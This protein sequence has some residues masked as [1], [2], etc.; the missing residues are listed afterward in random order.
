[1]NTFFNVRM[2]GILPEIGFQTY[3]NSKN[4]ISYRKWCN[5]CIKVDLAARVFQYYWRNYKNKQKNWSNKVIYEFINKMINYNCNKEALLH[6]LT[7]SNKFDVQTVAK[8]QNIINV[9]SQTC[10]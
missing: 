5:C 3:I 2:S 8:M 6:A 10:L 9:Y 7:E 1:M 4:N